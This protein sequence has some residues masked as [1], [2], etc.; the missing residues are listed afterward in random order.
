MAAKSTPS[1]AGHGVK[2]DTLRDC[3][4][5][6]EWLNHTKRSGART[7]LA[8]RLARLLEKKYNDVN[9]NQIESALSHFL[10]EVSN[11]YKKLCNRADHGTQK[12]QTAIRTL[13][14]L[15]E[16]VNKLLAAFYFLRYRVDGGFKAMGGGDWKDESVGMIALYA[17]RNLQVDQIRKYAN[18]IDRYFIDTDSGEYGVIPGGFGANELKDSYMLP[19]GEGYASGSEM[20]KDLGNLLDKNRHVNNLFLD[21]YSTTVVGNHGTDT[22]NIANAL[23][24]VRDFCRIFGKVTDPQDFKNHL[25]S[26][27]R[28]IEL[29]Q[30]QAHCQK[31][32]V[33]L[34]KI[35]REK[36]FSFTGY[37]RDL[38]GL[39]ENHIAKKM[40]SWFKAN[41]FEVK[42]KLKRIKT[43]SSIKNFKNASFQRGAVLPKN[44]KELAD[45]FT[46]NFFPYGFTFHGHDFNKWTNAYQILTQDWNGVI[47]DLNREGDG[48]DKLVDILN[49]AKCRLENEKRKGKGTGTEQV[50]A[51]EEADDGEPDPPA[52]DSDV[53]SEDEKDEQLLDE[54]LPAATKT[55][56]AKPVMTKAE[57]PKP[58]APK[59]DA[60]QNQG[61]KAEGAQNQ[62]KKAEGDTSQNGQSEAKS[63]SSRVSQVVQTQPSSNSSA[64]S[65]SSGVADPSSGQGPVSQAGSAD[66]GQ[67]GVQKAPKRPVGD[68]AAPTDTA[69]GSGSVGAGGGGDSGENGHNPV[70][71]C[72]EPNIENLWN[73]REGKTALEFC[74][75]KYKKPS[76]VP[77]N[78]QKTPQQLWDDYE[79]KKEEE[80]RKTQNAYNTYVRQ[81]K[82]MPNYSSALNGSAVNTPFD[83][84]AIS[85]SSKVSRQ[86]NNA[87]HIQQTYHSIIYNQ[88]KSD[89]KMHDMIQ[90]SVQRKKDEDTQW[91]KKRIYGSHELAVGGI[92][93][94]TPN[95]HPVDSSLFDF[96]KPIGRDVSKFPEF[97]TNIIDDIKSKVRPTQS[98]DY[99]TGYATADSRGIPNFTG[100]QGSFANGIVMGHPIKQ[101]KLPKT[102]PPVPEVLGLTVD[103]VPNHKFVRSPPLSGDPVIPPSQS[104]EHHSPVPT[105]PEPTLTTMYISGSEI[106]PTSIPTADIPTDFRDFNSLVSEPIGNPI[107][108]PNIGRRMAPIDSSNLPWQRAHAPDKSPIKV[109]LDQTI[110][111]MLNVS[112]TDLTGSTKND[113]NVPAPQ[114]I[115][116]PVPPSLITSWTIPNTEKRFPSPTF[117]PSQL[118]K[119]AANATTTKI[120]HEEIAAYPGEFYPLVSE[121]TGDSISHPKHFSPTSPIAISKPTVPPLPTKVYPP[122]SGQFDDQF[123]G[124]IPDIH[125]APITED[126][127]KIQMARVQDTLDFK[128]SLPA[129]PM[130]HPIPYDNKDP[131][132]QGPPPRFKPP[133]VSGSV[134]TGFIGGVESWRKKEVMYNNIKRDLEA[135]KQALANDQDR[136]IKEAQRYGEGFK[137]M[138][139]MHDDDRNQHLLDDV[140]ESTETLKFPS[141]RKLQ[142]I[143]YPNEKPYVAPP[144]IETLPHGLQSTE[145]TGDVSKTFI[146]VKDSE[147]LPEVGLSVDVLKHSPFQPLNDYDYGRTLMPPPVV[148][149]VQLAST[150]DSA[151]LVSERSIPLFANPHLCTDPWS[152]STS[153][154]STDTVQPPTSPPP[155]IDR[156]PPPKT[157]REMLC[158]FVGLSQYGL[159]G[160]VTEH[161]Y[162]LLRELNKDTSHPTDAIDVT[163]DLSTLDASMVTA[164][165]TEACLYSAT[166]IYRIKHRD[167]YAAYKKFKFESVYSNLHYSP[168]PAGL[169]CQLRD[170]VYACH[171]QLEFLKAQSSRDKLSGGWENYE[172]GSDITASKSPL[173]A[174]L[175]D[176][177]GSTFETHPFDPCNLCLKSR[178]RMGF[179]MEDL[180]ENKQT[181]ATLSSI[182]TPSCGGEGHDALVDAR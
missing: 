45:Y 108:D 133:D 36:R 65:A 74:E 1:V 12:P 80:E 166:V 72:L 178:V 64:D 155:A 75:V 55:E 91:I 87:E 30:L 144:V 19:H 124:S 167:D 95:H 18:V 73:H 57:A 175:T 138:V 132:V 171:H 25:Y 97:T 35:F 131:P 145:A 27:D 13:N 157:V 177:W 123:M 14:A 86:Q 150:L 82:Q 54:D 109:A 110:E 88:Q 63:P 44:A 153:A 106:N 22:P 48:L 85:E 59:P 174:F 113:A 170:Y 58:A 46:H 128:L 32:I 165:L 99:A 92:Q 162:S 143:L 53:E 6:L 10:N 42:E 34:E 78:G 127:N 154:S 181:G 7:Q 50:K 122:H 114:K 31:L 23:R 51:A 8:G 39:S 163:G 152:V 141:P 161:V 52:E 136:R 29:P 140:Q 81:M 2:L 126:T 61:K 179:Q 79:K 146:D 148:A 151:R 159:I 5:F 121:A 84:T 3:L 173:Q 115:D 89:K 139:H 94:T 47:S 158:W 49:G 66:A 116:P 76:R 70:K 182:L 164:K 17:K 43:L 180:P 41:L 104:A 62:G 117:P 129:E 96:E 105:Q 26:K 112:T 90:K 11:F 24:L 83:G 111:K 130:G 71:K 101:P 77:I 15:L 102:Y 103:A 98:T 40:A 93:T 56:A 107:S 135:H 37:A 100:L 60:A 28:C 120:P 137:N 38:K 168:D 21:V 20:A 176:D 160:V 9:R 156:L 134:T 119:I 118:P 169:L 147:S 69:S 142:N 125:G 172:Y 33:P 16:C 67:P 68:T 4:Q 149:G